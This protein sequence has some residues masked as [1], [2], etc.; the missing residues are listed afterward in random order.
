MAPFGYTK[1]KDKR[2]IPRQDEAKIIQEI[3][4][5]YVNKGMNQADIARNLNLRGK[6]VRSGEPISVRAIALFLSNLAYV[7]DIYYCLKDE[8]PIYVEK[9]HP[10]IVSDEI[11]NKAQ[12]IRAERRHVPQ[13]AKLGRYALSRL[14][15]C[16][17]CGQTLSFCMKYNNKNARRKLDK[18]RRELYVLNCFSSKGQKQKELHRDKPRCENNGIKASRLEEAVL[19][20]LKKEF[21]TQSKKLDEQKKRVQDGFKMGIYGAEEASNE[22]EEINKIKLQVNQ[23]LKELEDKDINSEIERKENLKKTIME[24]LTLNYEDSAKANELLQSVIDKIYYWKE[25]A[26]SRAGSKPF[27]LKIEYKD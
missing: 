2:L 20:N 4:D 21:F 14:L 1:D 24:I 3:F 15:V 23:Q 27:V 12:T 26:D 16:P 11:F 5:M 17:K 6:T 10:Q 13:K 18:T 25:E 22:I 19:T 9:A 7:G 8:D